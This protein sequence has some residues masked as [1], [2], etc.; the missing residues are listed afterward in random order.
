MKYLEEW[1]TW[2]YK[3]FQSINKKIA[4]LYILQSLASAFEQNK[5]IYAFSNKLQLFNKNSFFMIV[6]LLRIFFSFKLKMEITISAFYKTNIT[7]FRL[8]YYWSILVTLNK[9]FAR[10]CKHSVR[11]YR[12]YNH[13]TNCNMLEV[14]TRNFHEYA[15]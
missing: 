7:L 2:S 12:M 6:N 10:N 8:E 13:L 1:K 3:N 4:S 14:L 15:V 9:Y 5:N 11:F